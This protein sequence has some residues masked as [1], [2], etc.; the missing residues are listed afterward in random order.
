MAF[1]TPTNT[2]GTQ[3]FGIWLTFRGITLPKGA[4]VTSAKLLFTAK[5]VIISPSQTIHLQITGHKN[6]NSFYNPSVGSYGN[7]TVAWNRTTA[8]VVWDIASPWWT[9]GEE[10][11]SQNIGSIITEIVAMTDWVKGNPIKFFID[12]RN[13]NG[14]FPGNVLAGYSFGDDA[15][16]SP[17]LQIVSWT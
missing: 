9:V 1:V 8:C 4:T 10:Y 11:E 3:P 2:S 6:A 7:N 5:S 16:L 12:D 13:T 17:R 15:L 14:T